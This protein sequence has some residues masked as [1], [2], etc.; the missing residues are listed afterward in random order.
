MSRLLIPSPDAVV[1]TADIIVGEAYIN[2]GNHVGNESYVTMLNEVAEGFFK[3]RGVHPYTVD[4][5]VLLNTEF[6]V[7]L[8]SEAKLGDS[9]RVELGVNNF[10]RCGCDF[11]YKISDS[12]EDRLI[13]RA[14]FSFL[15]FDYQLGRLC[16]AGDGFEDFF[17]MK[18]VS[19]Q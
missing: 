16:D 11:I 15:C 5:Q 4:G 18:K 7:Q 2:A 12:V 17:V 13:A 3:R 14:K 6:S 9:L 8:K 1:F 10:H 19:A